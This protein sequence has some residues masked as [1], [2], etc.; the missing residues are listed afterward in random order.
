MDDLIDWTVEQSKRILQNK[1]VRWIIIDALIG[2]IAF[3]IFAN[4]ISSHLDFIWSVIVG[5]VGFVKGVG[6]C[7]LVAIILVISIL[8]F[9]SRSKKAARQ[10]TQTKTL[11]TNKKPVLLLRILASILVLSLLTGI[12]LHL[13]LVPSL[14]VKIEQT[15]SLCER[16]CV[17]DVNT[18]NHSLKDEAQSLQGQGHD[19]DACEYWYFASREDPTDGEARIAYQN[20]HMLSDLPDPCGTH[21]ASSSYINLVVVVQMVAGNSVANAVLNSRSRAMLQ[22]MDLRQQ[23]F[24]DAHSNGPMLHLILLNTG[25]GT[26]QT[27]AAPE[28]LAATEGKNPVVGVVNLSYGT[29]ALIDELNNDKIPVVS[30]VPVDETKPMPYL[31]SVAPSFQAQS[32]AAIH[33]IEDESPHSSNPIT[34][35]VFYRSGDIYNTS[36]EYS[37]HQEAQKKHILIYARS[38]T[39]SDISSN[40]VDYIKDFPGLSMVYFAGPTDDASQFQA[41]LNNGNIHIQI[42]GPDSMYQ[43][44]Y[45]SHTASQIQNFQSLQFTVFAYH[46]SNN[47]RD[48]GNARCSIQNTKQQYNP[49]NM[50]T[51]YKTDFDP[52]DVYFGGS[53]THDVASSDT[54][55]AYD[56]VSLM[57]TAAST[58]I[59]SSDP[60]TQKLLKALQTFTSA[61]P[62]PG[63][64]GQISYQRGQSAPYQKA[65]L[66]ITINK[67]GGNAITPIKGTSATVWG[68]CYGVP[69]S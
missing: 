8:I 30:V 67:Q 55:L 4:L 59:N 54:I 43:W 37:F 40:L 53:Y 15:N 2:A 58:V 10:K 42:L 7:L 18:I 50:A 29:D 5:N 57:D 56:A 34:V 48:G 46:D 3:G 14:P 65:V 51:D 41:A 66:L 60:P 11:P 35:V 22:A 20:Y 61:D 45:Q 52:G 38:Y 63:V 47:V 6:S 16:N 44:V 27:N 23:E 68:G 1:F 25:D 39:D 12:V 13:L 31:H 28:I 26:Q 62:F 36:I 19:K 24:N 64:S 49:Y 69:T 9:Y 21:S 32:D 33:V 17:I